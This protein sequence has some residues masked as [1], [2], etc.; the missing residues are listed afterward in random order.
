MR[1]FDVFGISNIQKLSKKHI[2]VIK[3]NVK[4][5]KVNHLTNK[6]D[7]RANYQKAI[8]FQVKV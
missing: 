5:C 4:C 6:I 3:N 2:K 8:D 7:L 1:I